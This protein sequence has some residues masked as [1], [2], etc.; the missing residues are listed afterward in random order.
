MPLSARRVIPA[1]AALALATGIAAAQDVSAP[2]FYVRGFGGASSVQDMALDP[3]HPEFSFDYSYDAG[4]AIGAALGY[5]I[6]PAIAVEL[7]YAQR[8]SEAQVDAIY[9]EDR[10][11]RIDD[12][13]FD[14]TTVARAVMANAIYSFAPSGLAG[15][16]RPYL[17][18]G[19][20]GV[21]LDFGEDE[22]DVE[23]AWQVLG[24]VAYAV[25]PR[26]E[27]FGEL[28]WFETD[29][30]IFEGSGD[31]ATGGSFESLDLL[32]GASYRF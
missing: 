18:G 29:G 32:V 30:G 23:F 31:Y 11:G 17:G 25:A 20:G 10:S 1:A 3:V 16:A 27:L 8:G 28:R 24:G 2:G 19:I 22:T 21:I 9:D 7:E 4:Y 6:T 12:W 14:E 15:G 26:W 13:T 5:A